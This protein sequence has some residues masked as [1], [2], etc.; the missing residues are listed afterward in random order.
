MLTNLTSLLANLVVESRC[1]GA[2][3]LVGG[4][5]IGREEENVGLVALLGVE[6][7]KSIRRS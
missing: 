5:V 6:V 7:V 4:G 2:L 1:V 3:G